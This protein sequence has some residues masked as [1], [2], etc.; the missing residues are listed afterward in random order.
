MRLKDAC[1]VNQDID[2][3]VSS[4]YFSDKPLCVVSSGN[5]CLKKAV[6]L[7]LEQCNRRLRIV[8]LPEIVD[9]DFCAG[10]REL[11]GDGTANSLGST[12][13]QHN[14][15][16]KTHTSSVARIAKTI[17]NRLQHAATIKLNLILGDIT[18]MA[19]KDTVREIV[20]GFSTVSDDVRASFGNM[21]TEQINWKPSAESWSVG[22]CLDHLIT[23]NRSYY[24]TFDDLIRG[25]KVTR[26]AERLPLF[27]SIFGALLLKY[28][29]PESKT[30][31]KA[32]TVF[33]ATSSSVPSTIIA[34]FITQQSE[35]ARR[36]EACGDMRTE[37]IIITS[38][39]AGFVTYS[40][41][42]AFRILLTHE[43]RHLKQ[44]KNVTRTAGFPA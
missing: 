41:L 19:S 6:T 13:H 43:R 12:R 11:L 15:A 4:G 28:L 30:K 7:T 42:D 34:D 37:K 26:F 1:V 10:T 25:S 9:R 44:A 22:Q 2:S 17:F 31:L 21:T 27:P 36:I 39:A 5:V 20:N 8:A 29:D 32:P 35:T 40:L 3:I 24:P 23:S 18:K 33:Q 14:F 16:V 38:P